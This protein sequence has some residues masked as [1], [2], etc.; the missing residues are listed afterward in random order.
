MER[1]SK[2]SVK[3]KPVSAT[4]EEHWANWEEALTELSRDNSPLVAESKT[5][6]AECL[7]LM[8]DA[9]RKDPR[10]TAE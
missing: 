7:E 6:A 3:G 2:R 1:H 8:Q 5:L 10:G 9:R 4:M